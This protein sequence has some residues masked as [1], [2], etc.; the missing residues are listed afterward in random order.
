MTKKNLFDKPLKPSME[1]QNKVCVV[2]QKG[3]LLL[4]A[5]LYDGYC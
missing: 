1:S 3:L 5:V 2:C 4:N